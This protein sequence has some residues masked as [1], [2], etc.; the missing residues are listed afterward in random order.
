[1]QGV[2]DFSHGKSPTP[3]IFGLILVVLVLVQVL[4]SK[5]KSALVELFISLTWLI[6][7]IIHDE[8]SI[9]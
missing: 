7:P 9:K 8:N 3:C 5:A 6:Y 2:G 1:M 4:E